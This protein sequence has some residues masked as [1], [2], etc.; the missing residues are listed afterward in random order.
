MILMCLLWHVGFLHLD[1]N[2]LTGGIPVDVVRKMKTL[3]Y[4]RLDHN[5]LTGTLPTEMAL[6]TEITYISLND[7]SLVGTIPTQFN[8]MTIIDVRLVSPV[9]SAEFELL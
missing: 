6:M 2:L 5:L 8:E 1:S 9:H 3:Q 4:L 7:N